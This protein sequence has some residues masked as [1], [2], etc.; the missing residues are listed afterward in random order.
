MIHHKPSKPP[1]IFVLVSIAP[2]T[3]KKKRIKTRRGFEIT[4]LECLFETLHFI[5]LK[6][7]EGRGWAI[8]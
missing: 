4:F 6:R 8:G 5:S 3:K 1:H 2:D 7:F